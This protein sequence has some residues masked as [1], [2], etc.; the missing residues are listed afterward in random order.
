MPE[1]G[2]VKISSIP[3]ISAIYYALLQCGYEYYPMERENNHI[4]RVRR[5]VSQQGVPSFFR[6]TR[7]T[8]CEVYP[9]WPRAAILETAT[10]YLQS[11][12]VGYEDFDGLCSHIM[13][14]SNIA[15]HERGEGLWDWLL[16]FPKALNEVL[17]SPGFVNYL[18]W[19][20]EW[21]AQQN[22]IHEKKL[23]H[24]LN[25]V[26]KCVKLYHSPVTDIQIV[27]SPIK[28]VYSS[29]YHMKG[30]CFIFSS[31]AFS[32]ESIIHEFLHHVIHAYILL[33]KEKIAQA[34]CQY[35]GLDS[36]YYLSRDD[37]GKCNA[38]EEFAVRKLTKCVTGGEYPADLLSYLEQLL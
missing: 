25:C 29:D 17:N 1:Y 20:Q 24:I 26:D 34:P 22:I 9:Y 16:G 6:G 37:V 33:L 32:D 21:I 36:T 4:N 7:Q 11:S 14:A 15:D 18:E 13:T 23:E 19:E 5:F 3:E 8:T 10:F 27:L 30:N 31:G 28:C 35:P 2:Q 38:F 12:C